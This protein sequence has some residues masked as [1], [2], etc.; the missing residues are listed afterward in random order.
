MHFLLSDP[1]VL[2]LG[3]YSTETVMKVCKDLGKRKFITVIFATMKNGKL[4]KGPTTRDQLNT[5]CAV[6][7]IPANK[8]QRGHQRKRKVKI[9]EVTCKD[10][11]DI[12]N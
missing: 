8:T 4:P 7:M 2:L 11:Y 5:R 12:L 9:H 3:I 10:T 1:A 6:E